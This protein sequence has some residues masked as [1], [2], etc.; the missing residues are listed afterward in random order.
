MAAKFKRKR[1][2]I[3]FRLPIE[4]ASRAREIATSEGFEHLS[5]W[6]AMAVTEYM[7]KR[8]SRPE[9]RSTEATKGGNAQSMTQTGSKQPGSSL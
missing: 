8:A 7:E 2:V 5:D 9:E 1:R 4:K 6:I 3:Y